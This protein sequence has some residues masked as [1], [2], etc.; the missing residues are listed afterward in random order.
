LSNTSKRRVCPPGFIMM[1]EAI[2][3]FLHGSGPHPDSHKWFEESARY[4]IGHFWWRAYIR[5]YA[6]PQ[7]KRKAKA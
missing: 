5:D 7:P 3:K 2:V 1:P 4:H 6:P